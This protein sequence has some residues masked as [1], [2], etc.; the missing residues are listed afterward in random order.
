MK[1]VEGFVCD[2]IVEATFGSKVRNNTTSA[3]ACNILQS[4]IV[5]R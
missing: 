2:E 3:R 4:A 1:K 5:S